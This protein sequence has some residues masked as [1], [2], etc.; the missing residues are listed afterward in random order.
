MSRVTIACFQ[1]NSALGEVEVNLV[2][3]L[4]VMA[5][6]AAAGADIVIF[7]ETFL[8]G[9]RADE[10]FADT[11]VAVPGPAVERLADAA[12]AHGLYVVMGLARAQ[13]EH[14]WFV[15]NSAILAGPEGV[16]GVYDK[17]HLGSVHPVRER[18]YFATGRRAPVW[19]TR[20]GA[21]SIQICN[22]LWYP[23]MSRLYALQGAELNVV[24][25]AG[26]HEFCEQWTTMLQARAIENQAFF[27][28]TNVAG[29]QKDSAFFGRAQVV[30]P[31][32]AVV[33]LGPLGVEELTVATVDLAD[34]Q[35][36]RRRWMIL[37]D[38]VP[39]LYQPL[40][41]DL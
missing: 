27:A 22:D 7:P 13:Q 3:A 21:L 23:E 2:R 11:A 15:Y 30:G 32:G 19:R 31:D 33:A 18:S 17:V 20:F 6:G 37:R 38:R 9:Y 16:L 28:Y 12:R 8:H 40:V 4:E 39:D 25:S 26:S 35:R 1:G 41:A 5:E 24:L 14:P 29:E 10:L 36:A 34:V